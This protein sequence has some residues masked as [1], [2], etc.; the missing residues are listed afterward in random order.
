MRSQFLFF[1]A[2]CCLGTLMSLTMGSAARAAEK[3][4][5]CTRAN[6]CHFDFQPYPQDAI[7]PHNHQWDTPPWTPA[8]WVAG[9][10]TDIWG[11]VEGFYSADILR[12]Q[13]IK[14]GVPI[15]VVGPNFYRL[16]HY[17]QRRVSATVDA[18]YHATATPEAGFFMLYD[19]DSKAPIGIYDRGGL[20]MQ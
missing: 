9:S 12:D 1:A 13:Y 18:A 15:L 14:G 20:Q 8:M 4:A 16:G 11:L 5:P 10:N 19:W 3:P 17:D 6:P 7:H 2:L